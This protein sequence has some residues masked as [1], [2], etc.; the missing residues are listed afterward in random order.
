MM[1]RHLHPHQRKLEKLC[2]A[3]SNPFVFMF[4]LWVRDFYYMYD[5]ND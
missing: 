5:L 1:A 2:V 3:G 4:H